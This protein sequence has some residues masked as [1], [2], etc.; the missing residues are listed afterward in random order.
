MRPKGTS[1]ELERRRRR[2][3]ELVA[4]GES[5]TVVARILGVL[6]TSVHRWRRL[7]LQPNGLEAKPTPGAPTRLSD[8]QLGQLEQL[9]LQ[10]TKAHGWHNQLWTAGPRRPPGPTTLPCFV[11]PGTRPQDS[12]AAPRVDQP[13]A[14]AEGPGT[15]R[16]GGG[17]LEGRCVALRSSG[18][19]GNARPTSS[20]SSESGF[21][22]STPSVQCRTL[23]PARAATPVLECWDRR[24]KFSAI[25]C[26]TP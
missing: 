15:Q 1:A 16:Q 3:V 25:S 21:A 12:Q 4:Q 23:A 26:I 14:E 18:T 2:A 7:A 20:S 10:G 8:E 13:E 5:P 11:P 9:L 22:F 17:T 6:P 24:D 19:P